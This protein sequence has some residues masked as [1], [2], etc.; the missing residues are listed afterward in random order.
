M[1]GEQPRPK[2]PRYGDDW[3]DRA[4]CKGAD[5]TLFFPS[6]AIGSGARPDNDT[7]L[8]ICQTCPVQ[9]PCLD[10]AL[11]LRP[12]PDGIWGGTTE[13]DRQRLRRRATA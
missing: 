1:R 10:Y 12:R 3:R 5:H 13:S 9:Q 11:A 6:A 7:A 8:A 2:Q 4:A